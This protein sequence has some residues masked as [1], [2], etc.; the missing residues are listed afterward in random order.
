MPRLKRSFSTSMLSTQ[1]STT[2]PFLN[3]SP[4]CLTR[5]VH[6]MS[7]TCTRPSTPSS[8]PTNTPKSVTLRTMPLMTDPIGYLSSSTVQGFCSICFM[9]SAMRLALGSMSSTTASTS[10]ATS[11]SLLGCL[12]RLFQ[13]I[14][15]TCTRPSTPC[16]SS[17]NA[18]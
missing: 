12:T 5:W 18:P 1:A 7:E 2:S 16:S 9:P 13:V 8:T 15:L 6:E 3:S 4:G 14:S 10:C 11:S 17:M